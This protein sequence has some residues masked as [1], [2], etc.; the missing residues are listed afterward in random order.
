MPSLDRKKNEELLQTL[1]G[2]IL[3]WEYE[4]VEFKQASNN[5]KQSEIGEYFSAISNEASL[6]GLQHG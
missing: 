5:Y 1:H 2:L 6:R 4:V 3:H